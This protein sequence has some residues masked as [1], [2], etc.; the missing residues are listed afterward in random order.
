MQKPAIPA[1]KTPAD[2]T[3][4]RLPKFQKPESVK[5]AMDDSTISSLLV[6]R[7]KTTS[8]DFD[9]DDALFASLMKNPNAA[10]ATM[11]IDGK[12]EGYIVATPISEG[13]VKGDVQEIKDMMLAMTKPDMDPGLFEKISKAIDSGPF[14]Y[15]DDFQM[16]K[17]GDALLDMVESF[18]AQLA[19]NSA[20]FIAVHVLLEDKRYKKFYNS[21]I[22]SGGFVKIHENAHT[23]WFG[24][25]DFVFMVFEKP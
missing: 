10:V 6:L 12:L 22:K 1:R 20:K 15:L 16:A 24:G 3:A 14:Y 5:L 17:R 18:H 9:I 11:K 2:K 23:N 8:L 13:W 25:K 19:G 7:R 4:G 21:M